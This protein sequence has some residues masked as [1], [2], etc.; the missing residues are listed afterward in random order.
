MKS[1]SEIL[2]ATRPCGAA[3]SGE[4]AFLDEAFAGAYVASC[5]LRGASHAFLPAA[6][7]AW[8][9]CVDVDRVQ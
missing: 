5:G 6:A 4:E 3:A 8:S 9:H 2:Q 1:N 7:E